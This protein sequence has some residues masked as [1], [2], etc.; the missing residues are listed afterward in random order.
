MFISTAIVTPAFLIYTQ[1]L[2]GLPLSAEA[3][4][5]GA[6]K[7]SVKLRKAICCSGHAQTLGG[8]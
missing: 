6:A 8:A 2:P 7:K 4:L 3:N 5:V 1:Q